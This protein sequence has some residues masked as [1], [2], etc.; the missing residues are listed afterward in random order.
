M[1]ILKFQAHLHFLLFWNIKCTLVMVRNLPKF[2]VKYIHK[3]F[4]C[5]F[6]LDMSVLRH[7]VLEG[8]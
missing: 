8:G 2:L 1:Q 5:L 7:P 6:T 4:K 3:V